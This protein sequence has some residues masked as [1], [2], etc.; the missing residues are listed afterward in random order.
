MALALCS[1]TTT[2]KLQYGPTKTSINSAILELECPLAVTTSVTRK[3]TVWM[4]RTHAIPMFS[5]HFHAMRVQ[6]TS[7]ETHGVGILIQYS[8]GAVGWQL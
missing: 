5:A 8:N 6:S 2:E 3:R 1:M 7:Y 4:T